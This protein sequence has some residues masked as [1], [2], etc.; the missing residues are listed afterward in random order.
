MRLC[1]L[2]EW[3]EINKYEEVWNWISRITSTIISLTRFWNSCWVKWVCCLIVV[4]TSVLG[5][6]FHWYNRSICGKHSFCW[7][8]IMT[9]MCCKSWGSSFVSLRFFKN[10]PHQMAGVT[11]LKGVTK[12]DILTRPTWRETTHPGNPD[13]RD[14]L[15]PKAPNFRALLRS[16]F[17]F[18]FALRHGNAFLRTINVRLLRRKYIFF[19]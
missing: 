13:A 9:D 12:Q 5:L 4:T 3:N 16:F 15:T 6:D 17:F 14:I 19:C 10:N 1:L 2:F 11:G 8:T 18:F 7:K